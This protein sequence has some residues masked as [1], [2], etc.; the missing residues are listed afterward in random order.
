M[1]VGIAIVLALAGAVVATRWGRKIMR[2]HVLVFVKKSWTSIKDLAR[3]PI[4]L[5]ALFGGSLGVTLAYICAMAASVAALGGGVSFAEVGAVYLGASMIAAAAPTPG[6][7]GALEAGLVAGLTGVGMDP[8]EAV[9]AVL[10]YRLV[11]YWLP[12]LPG[13]FGLHVLERRGLV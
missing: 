13:W 7:L 4:R 12:I 1:L 8:G 10:A 5:V 3:S 2:K 11:T 6:G 9:A